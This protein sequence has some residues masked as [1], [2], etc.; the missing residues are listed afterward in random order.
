NRGTRGGGGTDRPE[1][2]GGGDQV[3]PGE[4]IQERR[5][6]RVR[7][8]DE[9]DHWDPGLRASLALQAAM[10]LH[11]LELPPNLHNLP[12]N[13]PP[14]RLELRLARAPSAAAAAPTLEVGPLP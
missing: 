14:V 1:Q 7:V 5:L 2:P 13:T 6:P 8:P 3:G 9:R 12:P 10:H 4:P 11:P